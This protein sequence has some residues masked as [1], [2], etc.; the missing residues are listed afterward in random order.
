MAPSQSLPPNSPEITTILG[1]LF[2]LIVPLLFYVY[3][4]LWPVIQLY[5]NK[6][7]WVPVSAAC[8]SV[9]HFLVRVICV[10]TWSCILFHCCIVFYLTTYIL[11]ASPGPLS[12][13]LGDQPWPLVPSWPLLWRPILCGLWLTGLHQGFSVC[14]RPA[15][16][17]NLLG[18]IPITHGDPEVGRSWRPV[19]QTFDK[20]LVDNSSL[21]FSPPPLPGIVLRCHSKYGLSSVPSSWFTLFHASL[22]LFLT[23][24]YLEL[25][26]Q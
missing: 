13:P 10:E 17:R 7:S 4:L 12:L 22:P 14:L 1:L 3:S 8:L 19:G 20:E 21:F 24:A 11:W 23:L 18:V 6:L 2:S 16:L 25:H 9:Q 5:I 15:T 26:P